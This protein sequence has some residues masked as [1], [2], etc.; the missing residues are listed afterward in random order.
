MKMKGP[1]TGDQHRPPRGSFSACTLERQFDSVKIVI[2]QLHNARFGHG[3][4]RS[5]R[6]AINRQVNV[7][8][9]YEYCLGRLSMI[10]KNN[11]LSMIMSPVTVL[12]AILAMR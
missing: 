4:A 12:D 7:R 10:H 6:C 1:T 9:V 8:L 11:Q 3:Q 5:F 2:R